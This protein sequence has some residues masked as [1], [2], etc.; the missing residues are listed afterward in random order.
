MPDGLPA[1]MGTLLIVSPP[2]LTAKS[3]DSVND[4][5]NVSKLL[6]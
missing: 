1:A 6:P 3:Y 4:D 5:A 2:S